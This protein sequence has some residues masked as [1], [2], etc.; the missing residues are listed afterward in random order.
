MQVF[1]RDLQPAAHV[2]PRPAAGAAGLDDLLGDQ[3]LDLALKGAPA[4]LILKG[5]LDLAHGEAL[6]LAVDD[7]IDDLL[8]ALFQSHV[9]FL[10]Y[11]G[12]PPGYAHDKGSARV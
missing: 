6:V 7:E 12:G 3:L 11:L 9:R 5:G 8:L 2:I 1:G 4:E 10:E